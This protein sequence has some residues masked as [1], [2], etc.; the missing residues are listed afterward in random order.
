[1]IHFIMGSA[2]QSKLSNVMI[3]LFPEHKLLLLQRPT[4]IYYKITQY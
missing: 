1:M 3:S 2:E 4:S